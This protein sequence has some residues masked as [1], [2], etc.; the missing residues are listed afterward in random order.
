MTFRE[1]LK[2]RLHHD[3][4]FDFYIKEDAPIHEFNILAKGSGIL[5]GMIFVPT[6]IDLVEEFFLTPLRP[7]PLDRVKIYLFKY[8]GDEVKKGD[9]IAKLVG[10]SEVLL[11]AERTICDILS[12]LS[13]IA[14]YTRKKIARVS[15]FPVFLI[16]T[17]KEN[18]LTRPMYK[19]AVRVGGGRNHRAGFFDGTLIKDNDITVYQGV[20]SAIDRHIKKNRFLTRIEVEAR[21]VEQVEEILKDGRADTILLD[22][23]APALLREA[24]KKIKKIGR[25]YQ[26]EASGVGKQDLRDIARTGVTHISV[27]AL[28]WRA[29]RI[30]I[31]MK[32]VV[33]KAA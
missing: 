29:R 3:L 18:A 33:Q 22:N 19:Y 31:S 7:H 6:V 24:V 16:D 8:D 11:K 17:R 10:N 1:M 20:T 27:S 30:D 2:E 25:P 5:C 21:T 32:A 4:G 28:V 14:T 13:G 23:M 15:G 26:I 9:V 12:E